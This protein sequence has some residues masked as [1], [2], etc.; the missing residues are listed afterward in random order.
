M[1]Q[2]TLFPNPHP[3]R[4]SFFKI[5]SK[6]LNKMIERGF[7][8]IEDIDLK[9]LERI[10]G[11]IGVG[12]K[13]IKVI[14]EI[15]NY[16]SELNE[17]ST[18]I[19]SNR[20]FLITFFCIFASLVNYA[21]NPKENI[22]VPKTDATTLQS[23][24]DKPSV[25][26]A[27]SLKI[28]G[29]YK[30]TSPSKKIYIGQSID[31]DKRFYRYRKLDC[32][33][34]KKLYYSFMKYGVDKHKF[35]IIH[36][37]EINQLNKLEKYYVDLFQCF[38]SKYGLN[39]KDGGG[40][41]GTLSEESKNKISNSKKGRVGN[42]LGSKQSENVKIKISLFNKGNKYSLGR[43]V[44]VE[45]RLKQSIAKL[46]KKRSQETKNKISAYWKGKKRGLEFGEK[47]KKSWIIRKLK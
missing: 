39:L 47:I 1:S 30:I 17:K 28:C 34:Q 22:E 27:S 9:A 33:S 46:G 45:T 14:R 7:V 40:S 10:R 18:Q 36:Q 37:C 5:P 19:I 11:F 42:R 13:T 21:M 16:R 15:I 44:S 43:K 25:G 26:G 31:I 2:T 12:P 3:I 6:A 4:K 41:K 29:I 24:I 35:E 8:N 23:V 20:N 38:D 32:P